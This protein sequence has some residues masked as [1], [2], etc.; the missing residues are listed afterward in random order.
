M[1]I[2]RFIDNMLQLQ[3]RY[4]SLIWRLRHNNGVEVEF[5]LEEMALD[6]AK[7]LQGLGFS[8]YHLHSQPRAVHLVQEDIVSPEMQ[9]RLLDSIMQFLQSHPKPVK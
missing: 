4:P 7:A 5:Y 8:A 6:C 3:T 9:S 1:H 2:D